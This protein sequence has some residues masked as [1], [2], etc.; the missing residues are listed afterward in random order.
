MPFI[1]LYFKNRE[2]KI[3]SIA[4]LL[5]IIGFATIYS[6]NYNNISYALRHF[7]V[8][9][10]MF[11][12]LTLYLRFVKIETLFKYSYL[13]YFFSIIFLLAT[14]I[15]GREVMGAK[16]WIQILPYINIQPSEFVKISVILALGRYFQSINQI[17]YKIPLFYLIPPLLIVFIPVIIILKQPNLGTAFII[18]S[19]GLNMIATI[20][21]S[22]KMILFSIFAFII[23]LPLIYFNL[24]HDYQKV[25]VDM[26]L[27][28]ELDPLGYGYNIIQSKIAIGSGGKFGK[29][30]LMGT[31]SHLSFLPEKETDFIFSVF[32]EEFG[33]VGCLFILVLYFILLYEIYLIL[34]NAEKFFSKI[35]L[36]GISTMIFVHIM[37]NLGM[38]SG[39]LPVVGVPLPFLSYGGSHLVSVWLLIS[40]ICIVIRS[41]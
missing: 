3:I 9:F 27:N 28:P 5:T 30:F 18:S 21:I 19:I 4:V 16:R 20:C 31:Q 39:L 36:Y 14:N 17:Y 25:R 11:I 15:I 35:I 33:F 41:G 37:I 6:S 26:F 1:F 22:K 8:G 34:L 7:I 29:G 24:L 40:I 13:L 32:A 38:I 2:I 12:F 23:N 10:T